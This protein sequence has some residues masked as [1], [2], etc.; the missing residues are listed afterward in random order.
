M[1]VVL[2]LFFYHNDNARPSNAV[3][4]RLRQWFWAT[5][6]GARYT[7]RGFRPNILSDAAFAE[8][9]ASNAR[10]HASLKVRVPIHNVLRTEY[11]R[12][13]PLSNAFLCLL[14]LNRPRY[15]KDGTAIPLGEI[16]SRGNQNDKHHIFPRRY[17]S[18][19][20]IGSERIN[21]IANICYLVAQENQSI[22]QRAP[23]SY[24][25]DVPRSVRARTIALHSH[26]FPPMK[27]GKGI[28]DRSVNRGFKVFLTERAWVLARAFEHQCG[29]RLF[30]R[31]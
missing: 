29:M 21:S 2:T 3:N 31:P 19:Y 27:E 8:K 9:L 23:S 10:A 25:Q 12:P 16:S 11:G 24:I 18:K 20:G 1:L 7:G 28:L 13:G 30:E 6:V 15:L 14:R 17:L 22:G 5:A 4:R 26:Y